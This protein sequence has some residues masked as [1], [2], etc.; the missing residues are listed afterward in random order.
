MKV[1]IES[2]KHE[3]K[4]RRN[5]YTFLLG[6][7]LVGLTFGA[8]FMTVLDN[9]DRLLVLNQITAF[10]NGIKTKNLTYTLALKNSLLSNLVFILGIWILGLSVVG[11]PLILFLIFFKG[12][13]IG[14]AF[15][16]IIYKYKFLGVLIAF[17]Y[18]F[19]HHLLSIIVTM[20]LGYYS[21]NYSINL[22]FSIF[23]KKTISFHNLTQQYV[24][25]LVFSTTLLFITSL[26]EVYIVPSILRFFLAWIK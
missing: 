21:I 10:F 11:I 24:R 14:F 4:R 13:I 7:I 22:F 6:L 20:V 3:F 9:H 8:I 25:I 26:F 23:K 19:P 16:A 1:F 2:L 17:F 15:A 12:F 18:V 5:Q